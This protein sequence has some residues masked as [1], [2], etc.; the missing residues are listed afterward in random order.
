MVTKPV[1]TNEKQGSPQGPGFWV[2]IGSWA[3]VFLNRVQVPE[4]SQSPVSWIYRD[5]WILGSLI[6]VLGPH[7]TLGPGFSQGSESCVLL[8]EPGSSW[9]LGAWVLSTRFLVLELLYRT[10]GW[11]F[12]RSWVLG[13]YKAL[14]YHF[15]VYQL[16]QRFL[17]LSVRLTLQ[18][19][20]VSLLRLMQALF[21]Q[22]SLL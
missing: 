19:L 17:L 15:F 22:N 16:Q 11:V 18:M 2:V 9:V 10:L 7:R 5:F 12:M 4:G 3:L 6:K 1:K 8:Q 13:P 21:L 14:G 20:K